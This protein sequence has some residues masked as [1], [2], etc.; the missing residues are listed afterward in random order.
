MSAFL[1]MMSSNQQSSD[2]Q[3]DALMAIGNVTM[4]TIV[5]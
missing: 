1:M 5:T 3:E 2:L 4:A